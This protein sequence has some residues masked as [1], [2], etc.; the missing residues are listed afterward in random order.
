MALQVALQTPSCK[1]MKETVT[2]C[3]NIPPFL[4]LRLGVCSR[5]RDWPPPDPDTDLY[6]PSQ[7]KLAYPD[8]REVQAVVRKHAVRPVVL[9]LAQ[10]R[11]LCATLGAPELAA[12]IEPDS[13]AG[14]GLFRTLQ[15]DGT[16][17]AAYFVGWLRAQEAAARLHA[18]MAAAFPG[19]ALLEQHEQTF[20]FSIPDDNGLT[21]SAIFGTVE[22]ARDELGIVEYTVSQTSLEQVFNGFAAQQGEET[23]PVRGLGAHAAVDVG[24][25]AKARAGPWSND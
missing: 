17:S 8:A 22:G 15:S 11:A 13:A 21:L 7:V 14:G 5:S 20:R 12:A 25:G 3:W 6:T 4:P 19:Q 10:A 2:R 18:R 9:G 16:A 24:D 23:G 1:K